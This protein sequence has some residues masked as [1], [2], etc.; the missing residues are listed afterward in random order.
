MRRFP[1]EAQLD[2]VAGAGRL[3][4]G[5]ARALGDEV[6]RYHAAAE[7]RAEDGAALIG[8][9]LDEL[10]RVFGGMTDALAAEA[11]AGSPATRARSMPGSRRT[12][13]A[14]RPRAACAAAIPTCTSPT[15]C[16]STAA[17]SPS[18]RSN[19]TSA[20]APATRATTSPSC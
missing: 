16:C 3:D 13:R 1:A 6:A 18:T 11:V 17:P 4:D 5:L 19:S 9:I 2:R 15:S 7:V 14:A 12:S 20:S 8:E 10:G